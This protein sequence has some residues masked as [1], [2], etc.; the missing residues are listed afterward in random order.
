[1]ISRE[2]VEIDMEFFIT[3][4]LQKLQSSTSKSQNKKATIQISERFFTFLKKN[5]NLKQNSYKWVDVM[6]IVKEFSFDTKRYF[7]QT[8]YCCIKENSFKIRIFHK[9][10]KYFGEKSLTLRKKPFQTFFNI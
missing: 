5:Y 3:E 7:N 9:Y 10:L 2:E 8:D 4:V 6:K 1:L